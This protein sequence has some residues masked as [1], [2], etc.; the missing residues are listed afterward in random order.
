MDVVVVSSIRIAMGNR[1]T[2]SYLHRK[3]VTF[4]ES[5][6]E[7][8]N[9]QIV[10]AFSFTGLFANKVKVVCNLSGFKLQFKRIKVA[11]CLQLAGFIVGRRAPLLGL[12][13]CWRCRC[14]ASSTC[15]QRG[16]STS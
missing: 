8:A 6:K 11:T 14:T 12:W 15:S 10:S 13:P 3:S 1:Y 2:R 16:P 5:V 7:S 4:A 9:I